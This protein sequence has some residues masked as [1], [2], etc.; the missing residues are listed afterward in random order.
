[1]FDCS[2]SVGSYLVHVVTIQ[3]DELGLTFS[4]TIDQ[5]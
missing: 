3:I 1:M 2:Y 5:L 4:C